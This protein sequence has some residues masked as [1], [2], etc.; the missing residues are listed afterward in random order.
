[1]FFYDRVYGAANAVDASAMEKANLYNVQ[2]LFGEELM[3]EW[4]RG[5]C[6]TIQ[7]TTGRV[8]HVSRRRSGACSDELQQDQGATAAGDGRKAK[9]K[10]SPD[11]NG[12]RYSV[13]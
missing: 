10:R 3:D 7:S 8:I 1:M 5:E 13:S 2:G 9:R 6:K 12:K 4:G 11:A